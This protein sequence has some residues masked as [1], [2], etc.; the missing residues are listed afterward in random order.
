MVAEMANFA[1]RL[2]QFVVELNGPILGETESVQIA[3]RNAAVRRHL[4][5]MSRLVVHSYNQWLKW[6][7]T[8][9]LGPTKLSLL[10]LG[11]IFTKFLSE[12]WSLAAGTLIQGLES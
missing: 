2:Q 3:N 11:P 10:F 9:F 1:Y 6:V 4:I 12:N 8:D 5:K 7:Q